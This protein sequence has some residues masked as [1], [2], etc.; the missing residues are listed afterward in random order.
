MVVCT[1]DP[2][3]PLTL[4]LYVPDGVEDDVEIV[5]VEVPGE[6][7]EIVTL[8]GLNDG[9]G[10]EGEMPAARLTMPLNPPTLIKVMVEVVEGPDAP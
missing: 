8:M 2:L 5:N 10:P 9:I 7:E 3:V 6:P 1:I 4:T